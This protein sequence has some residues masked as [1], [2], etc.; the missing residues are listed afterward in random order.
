MDRS[1]L[2]LLLAASLVL[3]G[4][5][6]AAAQQ[7]CR[8][9]LTLKETR[10]SPVRDMQRTWTGALAVDASRC[11]TTSGAFEIQFTRQKEYSADMWFAERFTWRTG[12]T[13]VSLDIWWDEWVEEE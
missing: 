10:I 7:R 5:A 11:A 4:T 12:Q 8:P 2:S 13:E 1:P 3:L 9:A 6:Q